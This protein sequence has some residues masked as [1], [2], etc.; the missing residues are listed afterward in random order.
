M[1]KKIELFEMAF[2]DEGNN[3]RE[4]PINITQQTLEINKL[5]LSNLDKIFRMDN[6]K[7]SYLSGKREAN[8]NGFFNY[9]SLK[10]GDC[11]Q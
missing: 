3:F 7:I 1:N 4:I 10:G 9:P 5:I 11:L 6:K 8:F 2:S